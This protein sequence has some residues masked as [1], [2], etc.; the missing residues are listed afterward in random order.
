ML[1]DSLKKIRVLDFSHVV[2][3]PVCGMLL[4][5]LGADVVKIES[6]EGELGRAIGPPWLNGESVVAL[7]VNRNK[8]GLAVNL[9]DPAGRDAVLRMASCADVII[10][11]FRPG[12][13]QRF[14][15]A[16]EDIAEANPRII[17]CSISA[18][19]QTGPQRDKP[20]VDGVIQ[21]VTGLMSTLTVT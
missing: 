4:G 9:K 20:G 15:L 3:G 7:S 1:R 6:P 21:A 16:Y 12:V 13:M 19:G 8:R 2:A 14:G 10:E 18:Y 11:S 17:Y 5:D